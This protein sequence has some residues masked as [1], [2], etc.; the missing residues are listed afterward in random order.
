[1]RIGSL[2]SGVGGLEL[3]LEWAGVGHTVWQVEKDEY[4]RSTLERHWPQVKRYG[5]VRRVGKHNLEPVDLVCGGFP[6]Q[7]ISSPG[8]GAGLTG[9]RSG[10]WSEFARIVS[11][12]QPTWV[13][14][15]NVASGANLWVD[16]VVAGLGEISYQALPVPLSAQDVGAPH[17]RRRVFIVAHAVG[18]SIRDVTERLPRGRSH[19]VQ[20]TRKGVSMDHGCSR[21]L[22]HSSGGGRGEGITP[23]G[24]RGQPW[25]FSED[26]GWW[27]P[28][29]SIRGVDDG[30]SNRV[31]RIRALGNAVVPQC[32]EVIGHLVLELQ[33]DVHARRELTIRVVWG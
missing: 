3:G 33:R 9:Q 30:V 14:V 1:M 10:L 8:K 32:A 7:D 16:A 19:P 20:R 13:V 29:P 26:R 4:C 22:A 5:D 21:S 15:E 23:E 2:F 27:C 17:L 11:E 25:K 12:L 28:E 24:R 31:D 6:C 18:Q